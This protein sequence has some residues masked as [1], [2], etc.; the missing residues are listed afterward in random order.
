MQLASQTRS[1]RLISPVSWIKDSDVCSVFCP[2]ILSMFFVIF[3]PPKCKA[4]MQGKMKG[5]PPKMLLGGKLLF[6]LLRWLPLHFALDSLVCCDGWF[7]GA[8]ESAPRLKPFALVPYLSLWRCPHRTVCLV[9]VFSPSP[10]CHCLL[11]ALL[12]PLSWKLW[13]WPLPL[14]PF[15][16]LQ[17]PFLPQHLDHHPLVAVGMSVFLS[18]SFF[19]STTRGEKTNPYL[20]FSGRSNKFKHGYAMLLQEAGDWTQNVAILDIAWLVSHMCWHRGGHWLCCHC[21]KHCRNSR[22]TKR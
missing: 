2:A 19:F 12:S 17:E 3:H 1:M 22:N 18:S 21:P 4:E 10:Q 20:T 16:L 13:P 5:Q 11:A 9:G 14:L 8:A 7:F 15:P 6:S